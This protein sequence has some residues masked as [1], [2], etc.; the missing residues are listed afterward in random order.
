MPSTVTMTVNRSIL[1]IN[2]V[3][4]TKK[5]L[6]ALPRLW[7]LYRAA[8]EAGEYVYELSVYILAGS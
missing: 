7:M 8:V 6:R 1:N 4:Y 5:L 3:G 2:D